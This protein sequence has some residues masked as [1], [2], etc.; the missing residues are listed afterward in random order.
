MPI[1]FVFLASA[2]GVVTMLSAG[3]TRRGPKICKPTGVRVG[4]SVLRVTHC[5]PLCQEYTLALQEQYTVKN[6]R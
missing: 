5:V 2:S 1:T 4:C 6:K 3:G